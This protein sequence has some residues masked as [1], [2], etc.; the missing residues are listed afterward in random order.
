MSFIASKL[1]WVFTSPG[2]FFVL[3]LVA[4]AFLNLSH[5]E[6][7]R[8]AGA[9]ICFVVAIILF[10]I[11]M[12]PTGTWML[13]PLE[14]KYPPQMPQQVAG[15]VL[16]GGDEK[17]QRSEIRGQPVYLDSGRRYITFATLARHYPQAKLVFAGGSPL[18]R[19]N[20]PLKEAQIV[21][22]VLSGMGVPVEHMQFEDAS[23]N[24][25]ENAVNAYNLVHPKAD[26]KWLLVTSAY[27]MPRAL[28]TFRKAGWNI[29]PATTGYITDGRYTLQINFDFSQHLADIV[30]A[31]HEYIGLLAYWIMGYTDSPWSK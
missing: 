13:T 5:V 11:G 6:N 16:I 18:V 23:R 4:G 20:S 15:I 26:E 1:L 2:N 25:R 19:P 28:A 22:E 7:R 12:L 17:A 10:L 30:C 31:T 24:T 3:L 29:E 14:N 9:T 21:K 27:H 8:K